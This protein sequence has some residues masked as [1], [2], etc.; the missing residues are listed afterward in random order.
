VGCG[1]P[2]ARV[3]AQRLAR[4]KAMLQLR[5]PGRAK[6]RFLITAVQPTA[7]PSCGCAALQDIAAALDAAA[8]RLGCRHHRPPVA[9]VEARG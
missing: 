8:Y 1:W 6:R 5:P 4:A 9:R 7:T 2:V 3:G